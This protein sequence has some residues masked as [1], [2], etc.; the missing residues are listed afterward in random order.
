MIGFKKDKTIF[1]VVL[2]NIAAVLLFALLF[3]PRFYSDM[4]IFMQSA[5]YGIVGVRSS[6]IVFSNVM[7]GKV[8]TILMEIVPIVPWY[9]VF[10]YVCC[11]I[12]LSI[13]TLVVLKR[14][15]TTMGKVLTGIILVFLGFECYVE[16]N[17]MKTAVVL[18]VS[19]VCLLFYWCE[20]KL[21][22]QTYI[23]MGVT[24][25]LFVLSSMICLRSFLISGITAFGLFIIYVCKQ[26]CKKKDAYVLIGV[27]MVTIIISLSM[28]GIDMKLYERAGKSVVLTYRSS[29]EKMLGYGFPEG[30]D[31]FYEE[32]NLEEQE[33]EALKQGYFSN[34]SDKSLELIKGISHEVKPL[35]LDTVKDFFREVPIRMFETG[36]LYYFLILSFIYILI[37]DGKKSV[38]WIGF[39]VV[40]AECF[41]LYITNGWEYKWISFIIFVPVSLYIIFHMK[42]LP[43]VEVK[44]VIVYLFIASIVLYSKFSPEIASDVNKEPMISVYDGGENLEEDVL[45]IDMI[46]YLRGYSGFQVY[47]MSY[48]PE[49]VYWVNG[50]YGLMGDY[51][52]WTRLECKDEEKEYKWLCNPN[53]VKVGNLYQ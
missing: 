34:I 7:I 49:N 35:S 43:S 37:G 16:P 5:V 14:N 15:H 38:L 52:E 18:S 21:Y 10:H 13:I 36:A 1:L 17:Y 20:N 32:Y 29:I 6:Y 45:L 30:N 12:S 33:Y 4:D 3:Y 50:A 44:T 2:A 8:L 22:S 27:L 25:I 41:V 31:E 26:G 23:C 47:D 51:A 53:K 42:D 46:E 9:I 40:L 19:A 24:L 39:G 28:H 48:V 11:F